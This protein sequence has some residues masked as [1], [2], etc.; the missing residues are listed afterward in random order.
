MACDN[1]D[2]RLDEQIGFLLRQANQRHTAIFAKLIPAGLT[3]TQFAALA[4]LGETGCASQ[5]AL[6]RQTSM[7]I[8]TIKGVVDR[9]RDKNLIATAHDPNDKRRTLLSLTSVGK[10]ILEN[11]TTAARAITAETLKP[12]SENEQKTL[13]QLLAKIC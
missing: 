13:Q 8:A 12:L 5:N 4:R 2:Y 6:G 3:P 1:R 11:A 10:T 9:L 7:D